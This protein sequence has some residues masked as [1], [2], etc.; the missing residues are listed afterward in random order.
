MK[1]PSPDDRIG[2]PRP[3]PCFPSQGPRTCQIWPRSDKLCGVT[4]RFLLIS[5]KSRRTP[6][7]IAL[8]VK[9]FQDNCHIPNLTFAVVTKTH[10][11][12]SRGFV[13]FSDFILFAIWPKRG[14]GDMRHGCTG[15]AGA[16]VRELA[17]TTKNSTLSDVS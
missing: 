7:V 17:K 14:P 10:K 4:G 5:P 16:P 15:R 13:G 6:D 12:T 1:I 8:F 3:G 2:N 9:G 11:I